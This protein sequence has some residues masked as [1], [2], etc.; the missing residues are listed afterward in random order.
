MCI[1]VRMFVDIPI[2]AAGLEEDL[3][4][5]LAEQLLGACQRAGF[6]PYPLLI[7]VSGSRIPHFHE[8]TSLC[9]V[10]LLLG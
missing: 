1:I 9:A 7:S 10:G 6:L 2:P 3:E 5:K 8:D 4:G